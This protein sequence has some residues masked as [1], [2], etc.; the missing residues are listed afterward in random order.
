M[1]FSRYGQKAHRE[2]LSWWASFCRLRL[3][4]DR[5]NGVCSLVVQR[6]DDK[7]GIATDRPIRTAQR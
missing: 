3:E 1:K 4:T 7:V 5:E 6:N 2:L